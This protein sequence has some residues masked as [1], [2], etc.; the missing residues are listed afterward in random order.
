MG[1][2]CLPDHLKTAKHWDWP[3]PF[4]W[5]PRSWTA[6]CFGKRPPRKLWGNQKRLRLYR[7]WGVWGLAPIG[8][9]DSFLVA[10]PPFVGVTFKSGWH[11]HLGFRPDDVD[12]YYALSV[13]RRWY[14]AEGERDTS[15]L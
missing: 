5:V 13:L 8:E 6:F 9:P 12:C 14:P 11:I 2:E 10:W 1:K 3:W 15:T 7:K 4:K